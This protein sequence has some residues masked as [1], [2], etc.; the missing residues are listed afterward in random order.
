[1]EVLGKD[2]PGH[3][4]QQGFQLG[5]VFLERW[6]EVW[7]SVSFLVNR[8][9]QIEAVEQEVPAAAGRVENPQFPWVL[10][11]SVRDVDR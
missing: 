9:Q 5:I 6:A 8:E 4:P 11:R 2:Q 10:L 3:I 1:M 7:V